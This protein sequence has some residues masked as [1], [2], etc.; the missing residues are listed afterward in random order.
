MKPVRACLFPLILS[1]VALFLVSGHYSPSSASAFRDEFIANY[2]GNRFNEQV[3]LVKKNKDIIPGEVK[4]LIGD[5]M[6]PGVPYERRMYLLDIASAMSSM[7]KYWHND[8]KPLIEVEMLQRMEI[9]KERE[10]LV[11][12][13]KWTRYEKFLGNIIMNEHK[14]QMEAE[15]LPPVIFPHWLHRVWF[16]CKVCHPKVFVMKKGGN[17]ISN[18]HILEGKQC[19]VCHDGK[20]S[21]GAKEK[22]ENCHNAGR[23]EGDRLYD[24]T[25]LDT[26]RIKEVAARLG[27]EWNPEKLNG[28]R[29]PLDRFGFI[30]WVALDNNNAF[31]P[32]SSLSKDFKEEIRDNRILFET[33]SPAVNNVLFDHKVHSTRIMCETCHPSIFTD[34]LGDNPI[35]M[36]DMASGRYCGYCH[37][38]VSFTFADCLR[39]HNQPKGQPVKDALV[40][41]HEIK[42]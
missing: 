42:P 22:C 2:V 7:Y 35:K 30:D 40:H 28:G 34:K 33:T 21:F 37:G 29:L 32:V 20:V 1:L 13:E 5:A 17:D 24:M 26:K 27:G 38:K 4:S 39:C 31:R 23:P 16:Q 6:A 19:G 25:K 3:N 41:R 9:Q 10:R 36:S 14:A 12:L 11:E 15:Q 18:A 8:D